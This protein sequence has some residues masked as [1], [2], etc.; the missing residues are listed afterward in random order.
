MDLSK[1]NFR[2]RKQKTTS[3]SGKKKYY[4]KF[5]SFHDIDPGIRPPQQY[6]N[7]RM[8]A[9]YS[10]ISIGRLPRRTFQR[11]IVRLP[12]EKIY[13]FIPCDPIINRAGRKK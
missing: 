11:I 1:I 7:W 9:V 10:P 12:R 13:P 4:S 5:P 3:D 8:L 6:K 2:R